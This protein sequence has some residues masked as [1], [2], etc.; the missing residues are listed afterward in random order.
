MSQK[1][2]LMGILKEGYKRKDISLLNQVEV[3]DESLGLLT[4]QD[5]DSIFLEAFLEDVRSQCHVKMFALKKQLDKEL[6]AALWNTLRSVSAGNIR[7][8]QGIDGSYFTNLFRSWETY[9]GDEFND[10]QQPPQRLW[11]WID[12]FESIW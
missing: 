5:L 11:G 7:S 9:V 8:R 3:L 4:T 12:Y 6:E 10:Y 2:K 1:R